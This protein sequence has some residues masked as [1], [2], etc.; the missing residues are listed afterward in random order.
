[1]LKKISIF[2]A[3]L[4][5]VASFLGAASTSVL[6]AD[7]TPSAAPAAQATSTCSN[8][9][10]FFGLPAWYEYLPVRYDAETG[11][12]EVVTDGSEGNVALLI[13]L[14]AVDILFRLGALVAVVFV[15][16]GGFMFVTSQGEPAKIVSARKAILN[17]VIGLIIVIL[18]S[19]IVKFIAKFLSTSV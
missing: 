9:V 18:A 3:V 7:T 14:A 15:V 8:Q 1:M 16:Y 6:A 2:V 5:V 12:C 11:G 19:Q 17:A 10:K 13:M 4:A